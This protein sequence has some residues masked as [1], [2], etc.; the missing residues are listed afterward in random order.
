MLKKVD[1]PYRPDPLR[2]YD[3]T[4]TLALKDGFDEG[5]TKQLDKL[6]NDPELRKRILL[7]LADACPLVSRCQ[8]Q[9]DEVD[10]ESCYG[11]LAD[12][13]LALIGDE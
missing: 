6:A 4:I 13:I 9:C 7:E 1:N 5:A 2:E 3:H 8:V 12:K 11:K 10:Y